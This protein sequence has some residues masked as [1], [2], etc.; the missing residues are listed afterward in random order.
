MATI[1]AGLSSVGDVP[2][3][4]GAI[5]KFTSRIHLPSWMFFSLIIK[6]ISSL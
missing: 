3:L 2:K 1:I 6:V 4:L 5:P